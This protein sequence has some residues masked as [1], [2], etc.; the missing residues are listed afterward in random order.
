MLILD[1]DSYRKWVRVE[2]L[3]YV[4]APKC[5]PKETDKGECLRCNRQSECDE[6]FKLKRSE[7][8]LIAI[9]TM[10]QIISE[11]RK[12]FPRQLRIKNNMDFLAN[13]RKCFGGED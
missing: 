9:G 12:L 13:L 3:R 6:D 11:E 8:R 1:V 7:Q 4:Y 5:C 10:G 2:A